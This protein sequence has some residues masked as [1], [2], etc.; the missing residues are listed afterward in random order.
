MAPS[1]DLNSPQS[2]PASAGD[3]RD[4]YT[5]EP[6][7]DVERVGVLDARHELG[8]SSRCTRRATGSQTPFDVATARASLRD[9]RVRELLE[10]RR[11]RNTLVDILPALK[12]EDS[13]GTVP[14][15]WDIVVYNVTRS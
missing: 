10:Q 12:H 1:I 13:H 5:R 4:T 2:V 7:A 6:A 14:L 8:S 11:R 3:E 15:G 9:E